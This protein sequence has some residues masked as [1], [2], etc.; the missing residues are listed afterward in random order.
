MEE[1]I[2]EDISDKSFA[3]NYH[4]RKITIEGKVKIGDYAFMNCIALESIEFGETVEIGKF[5]FYGCTSLKHIT[6]PNS[7]NEIGEGCFYLC[8]S[9][10]SIRLSDSITSIPQHC[11][12]RCVE[13]NNIQLPIN[14]IKICD[15][16][17]INC[18]ELENII[19]GDKI[20][21]IGE[22]AFEITGLTSITFPPLLKVIEDSV[23]LNC[24]NLQE[25]NYG[26][27]VEIIKQYAFWNCNELKNINGANGGRTLVDNDGRT[28]VEY[29]NDNSSTMNTNLR[30]IESYAFG[31]CHSLTKFDFPKSLTTICKN[32][33]VDSKVKLVNFDNV[34]SV[35]IS[36]FTDK[37][38]E[39]GLEDNNCASMV[40]SDNE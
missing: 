25:V 20:T 23:C 8:I 32:A 30:T 28:L 24:P 15:Y 17:F 31:C 12:G 35:S 9:L 14:L 36:K 21:T 18:R 26:P 34:V 3:N 7:V 10:K 38:I 19:L 13:L 22:N 37:Q 5:A 4:L 40:K 6:I 33:F 11:F 1:F 39:D 16:A 27:N 29:I 2:S